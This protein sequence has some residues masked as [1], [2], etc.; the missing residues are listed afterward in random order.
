MQTSVEEQDGE[1]VRCSV[2]SCRSIILAFVDLIPQH[3]ST[4]CVWDSCLQ[5]SPIKARQSRLNSRMTTVCSHVWPNFWVTT[6]PSQPTT[7]A[8]CPTSMSAVLNPLACCLYFRVFCDVCTGTCS[9]APNCSCVRG[10]PTELWSARPSPHSCTLSATLTKRCGRACFLHVFGVGMLWKVRLWTQGDAWQWQWYVPL[11]MQGL[12]GLYP[13]PDVYVQRLELFF[14]G[15]TDWFLGNAI[16]SPY[17]W[18][19]PCDALPFP[20]FAYHRLWS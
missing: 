11:D 8:Q 20:T 12:V 5:T 13:S 6:P 1:C 19:G 7:T 2:D 16:P 17:Y 14:N 4:M 10:T 15:S 3:N 9:A 18:A